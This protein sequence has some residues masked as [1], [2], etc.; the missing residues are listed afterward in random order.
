MLSPPHPSQ[1]PGAKRFRGFSGISGESKRRCIQPN[2]AY[3]ESAVEDLWNKDNSWE[4]LDGVILNS[5]FGNAAIQRDIDTKTEWMN[6]VPPVLAG[7][8]ETAP[9][10]LVAGYGPSPFDTMPTRTSEMNM[11]SSHDAE[12][13][14]SQS[15]AQGYHHIFD[16]NNSLEVNAINTSDLDSS[17][18]SNVKYNGDLLGNEVSQD[19]SYW[20]FQDS[21]INGNSAWINSTID[22]ENYYE[23]HFP[24]FNASYGP[25]TLEMA[26]YGKNNLVTKLNEAKW[27]GN[28]ALGDVSTV[29]S[30]DTE[31]S[32]RS[33]RE[34]V[35]DLRL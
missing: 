20:S 7:G 13:H 35:I 16:F 21:S 34:H 12:R 1:L 26:S 28:D 18:T 27:V 4:G 29:M 6:A 23:Y 33:T 22:P 19:S 5:E 11:Q 10:S 17:H 24:G 32:G 3:P 15:E 30:N 31:F 14:Y 9:P 2:E 25:E 8:V